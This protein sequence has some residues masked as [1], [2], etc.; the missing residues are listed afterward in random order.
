[1]YNGKG[2]PH[3]PTLSP[4]RKGK[5]RLPVALGQRVNSF[6]RTERWFHDGTKVR[7]RSIERKGCPSGE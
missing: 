2:Y 6:D 4:W 1:M 5:A 3:N 7:L